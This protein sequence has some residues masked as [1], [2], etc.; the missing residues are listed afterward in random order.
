MVTAGLQLGGSG[1]ASAAGLA[2]VPFVISVL[3]LD[4]P[5]P[6]ILNDTQDASWEFV[7]VSVSESPP[8]AI[9][10]NKA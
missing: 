4:T 8:A 6:D 10:A 5:W 3:T 2:A 9:F 1:E 7:L